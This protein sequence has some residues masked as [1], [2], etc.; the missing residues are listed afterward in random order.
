MERLPPSR[1]RFY[2]CIPETAPPGTRCPGDGRD[3]ASTVPGQRPPFW[4]GVPC[5]RSSEGYS[6]PTRYISAT[7]RPKI[8]IWDCKKYSNICGIVET[9]IYVR[10]VLITTLTHLFPFFWCS[11]GGYARGVSVNTPY[12][13]LELLRH[14]PRVHI[15]PT[16][17]NAHFFGYYRIDG[18]EFTSQTNDVQRKQYKGRRETK[19]FIKPLFYVEITLYLFEGD[20]V[21]PERLHARH[22]IYYAS[23]IDLAYG[24]DLLV[25]GVRPYGLHAFQEIHV[26][27]P[28]GIGMDVH[29]YS[30]QSEIVRL[31]HLFSKR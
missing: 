26:V 9:K 15:V 7:V 19:F 21:L 25:L 18:L 6:S 12:L 8:S 23:L 3:T 2:S 17:L 27:V 24:R 5:P 28:D 14:S 4:L 22:G 13:H 20:I 16:P 29:P 30:V 1:P 31:G 11:T 10:Q